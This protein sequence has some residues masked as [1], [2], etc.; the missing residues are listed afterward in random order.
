[1]S[2]NSANLNS[3]IEVIGF[4]HTGLIVTNLAESMKFYRDILGFKVLQEHFDNSNYISEITD[5][6]NLSARYAKLLIPGGTVLEL[7]T[8]PSHAISRSLRQ[9]HAPGEAHL[10]L[11]VK[12]IEETFLKVQKFNLQYLSKPVLSSEGIA[13]VFF[14]IDPDGYRIEFVEMVNPDD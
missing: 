3:G 7:L 8:Y 6:P 10:A 2:I 5:I 14:V 12:S 9:I 13:K 11:Q 4:R 1:M